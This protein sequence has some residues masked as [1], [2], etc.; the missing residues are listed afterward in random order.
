M[1]GTGP[2]NPTL[3]FTHTITDASIPAQGTLTQ[4][5][6]T[7]GSEGEDTAV[8][9]RSDGGV[10]GPDFILSIGNVF[11][12]NTQVRISNITGSPSNIGNLPIAIT[13]QK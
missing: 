11:G 12:G 6:E 8:V 2:L 5:F 9:C 1:G 10:I 4:S 13:I 3:K 7:P